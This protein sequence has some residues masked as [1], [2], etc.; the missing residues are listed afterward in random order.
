MNVSASQVSWLS[1]MALLAAFM[2]VCLTVGCE[3]DNADSGGNGGGGGGGE[4]TLAD[5][6]AITAHM[7]Y[8]AVIGILGR[9]AD[10]DIAM[11]GTGSL[12]V[13]ENDRTWRNSDG[14]YIIVFFDARNDSVFEKQCAGLKDA[15]GAQ[16][17]LVDSFYS[18]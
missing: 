6:N 14:S 13:P 2:C 15:S 8:D 1:R 10:Q 9:K 11:P 16:V 5:Y 12:Y 18:P 7:T 3:Q 17:F 4:I